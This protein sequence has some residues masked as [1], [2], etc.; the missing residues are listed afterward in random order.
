MRTLICTSWHSELFSCA[1]REEVKEMTGHKYNGIQWDLIF[2]WFVL[3]EA[4]CVNENN[5]AA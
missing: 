5:N 3:F 2:P 4:T 1:I